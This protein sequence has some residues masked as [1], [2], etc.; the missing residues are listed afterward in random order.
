MGDWRGDLKRAE[1]L[2][3]GSEPL[4]YTQA[5]QVTMGLLYGVHERLDAK[6]E[7]DEEIGKLAR[8]NEKSIEVLGAKV[9]IGIGLSVIVG[10]MGAVALFI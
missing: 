2:M 9:S 7:Q 6:D 8:G 4:T 10:I 3:N 5:L 1:G